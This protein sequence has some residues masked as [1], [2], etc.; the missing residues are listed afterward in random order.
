MACKKINLDLIIP[1]AYQKIVLWSFLC[2]LIAAVFPGTRR[3]PL[4]DKMS[5]PAPDWQPLLE[6]IGALLNET[7][8]TLAIAESTTGGLLSAALLSVNGAAGWY[9]GG[10]VLY[11]L[12]ARSQYAGWTEEDV[13]NYR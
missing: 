4:P 6:D 9:K 11:T 13:A 2:R 1:H 5:Y 12:D 7:G 8:Q 3:F 10:A